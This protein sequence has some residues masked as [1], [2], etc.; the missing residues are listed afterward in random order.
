[1]FSSILTFTLCFFLPMCLLIILG[2]LFEETLIRF[3]Q[4]IKALVRAFI[5]GYRGEN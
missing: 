5:R 1:M 3:E 2:I 4:H